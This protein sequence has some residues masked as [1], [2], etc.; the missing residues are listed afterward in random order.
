MKRC[1]FKLQTIGGTLLLSTGFLIGPAYAGD[2]VRGCGLETLRGQYITSVTG[3]VLPPAFGSDV[4]LWHQRNELNEP[5]D[6]RLT[7]VKLTHPKSLQDLCKQTPKISY[8]CQQLSHILRR[9][10]YH[11][12]TKAK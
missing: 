5:V 12:A 6:R 4:P 2:A 1:V 7:G 3:T 11:S 10:L 9:A 8:I